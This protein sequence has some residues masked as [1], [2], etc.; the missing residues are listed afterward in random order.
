MAK[1][2]QYIKPVANGFNKATVEFIQTAKQISNAVENLAN[3]LDGLVD[4]VQDVVDIA[5]DVSELI[6]TNSNV[7]NTSPANNSKETNVVIELLNK[8]MKNDQSALNE[9]SDLLFTEL[10][11]RNIFWTNEHVTIFKNQMLKHLAIYKENNNKTLLNLFS[12]KNQLISKAQDWFVKTDDSIIPAINK[13]TGKINTNSISNDLIRKTSAIRNVDSNNYDDL[14][15]N[16]QKIK[17]STK[18]TTDQSTLVSNINPDILDT[19][20]KATNVLTDNNCT[21]VINDDANVKKLIISVTQQSSLKGL[22]GVYTAFDKKYRNHPILLEAS[23]ELLMFAIQHQQSD[24]IN[25][26]I[27]GSVASQ[28][29]TRLPEIDEMLMRSTSIDKK[30]GEQQYVNYYNKLKT[31]LNK[32]TGNNLILNASNNT[33]NSLLTITA[34]TNE[35]NLSIDPVDSLNEEAYLAGA[36]ISDPFTL[37]RTGLSTLA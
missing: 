21:T 30:L 34:L 26:I 31:G 20:I 4:T 2:A 37:L 28:L 15:A 3:F 36:V 10:T 16:S 8:I 9:L 6:N 17:T 12:N 25:E 13:A 1:T 27:N 23:Y 5:E 29:K 14:L 19:Y 33:M 11:N 7:S 24:L 35:T 18:I 22:V 32:V